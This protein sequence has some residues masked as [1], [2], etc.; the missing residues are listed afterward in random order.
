MK[1]IISTVIQHFPD[2]LITKYSHYIIYQMSIVFQ[3]SHNMPI[4]NFGNDNNYI[5]RL[6]EIGVLQ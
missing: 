5:Y 2:A 3:R 1:A 6:G 4:Y